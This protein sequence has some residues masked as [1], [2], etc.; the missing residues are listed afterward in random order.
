MTARPRIDRGRDR[1]VTVGGALAA[2]V[3]L[4]AAIASTA[5]PPGS[6]DG[7]WLPI[8]L[9]LAGAAG[10]A[11][12]A[13]LPFFA[14]TIAAAP[15]A[16]VW[17]RLGA[18]AL[19]GGGFLAAALG[20]PTGTRPLAV[21]G[22]VAY[23]IGIALVAVAALGPLRAR[24][25]A[26][27]AAVVVGYTIALVDVIGGV[28][29]MGLFLAGWAG[30][31][32]GA[33]AVPAAHAWLNLFGFV[34][35]TIAATM[36]HLL[37]TV[38]G[39]RIARRRSAH[40]AVVGLSLGPPLVAGGLLV[41]G[42][43]PPTVL[44][45]TAD[46]AARAGAVLVAAAAVALAAFAVRTWRAR[47]RWTT[48]AGWHRAIVGGLGSAVAWFAIGGWIAALPVVGAGA[49]PGAVA[50]SAFIAP[51][52]LG[53]VG[54]ALVGSATH[55]L[56]SIGPGDPVRHAAQRARLGRWSIARLIALDAGTALVALGL[57]LGLGP[58][59]AAG[60]LLYAGGLGVTVGLFAA[61]TTR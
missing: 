59:T 30:L 55:L 7:T 14:S 24:R 22:A 33:I 13:V 54:L 60:L 31:G 41:R 43:G 16:P 51:L 2:L 26:P 49:D 32:R 8:H 48:D 6:R 42:S 53:W 35:L 17:L 38:A 4:T 37:P 28:S 20:V 57:P 40:L 44:A 47:G 56:P 61:A 23:A 45:G 46:L 34:G 5:L 58:V 25:R 3:L 21:A 52:A 50:P 12:A 11:I 1:R 15:P 18:L 29:L 10:L 19:V 9:A 39:T 36:L 27:E